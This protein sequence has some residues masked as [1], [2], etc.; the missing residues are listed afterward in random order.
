[1]GTRRLSVA[2][3]IWAEQGKHGHDSHTLSDADDILKG[4]QQIRLDS[5]VVVC[6][7]GI[8]WISDK[9]NKQA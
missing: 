2:V 7:K 8:P 1:M 5:N 3:R 4:K 9:Q 6:D